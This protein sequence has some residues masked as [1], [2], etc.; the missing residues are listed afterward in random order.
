MA[1]VG[2]TII[3]V[4]GDSRAQHGTEETA[5]DGTVAMIDGVAD[6]RTGTGADQGT[7][8]LIVIGHGGVAESGHTGK[9]QGGDEQFGFHE[10]LHRLTTIPD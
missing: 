4:V 3:I 8:Q 7:S 2:A 1:S 10:V 9:Q 6:D 5:D